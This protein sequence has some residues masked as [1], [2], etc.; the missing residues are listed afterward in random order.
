M[1]V[2]KDIM[3]LG[4]LRLNMQKELQMDLILQSLRS[5]YS[6]F[7]I[8]FH[9]N[10]LDCTIPKLVNI[11]VTTERTLKSLRGTVLAVER[12]SSER[13][14]SWKK[15]NKFAK[16]Q[17]KESKP[18]NDVPKKA[19]AKK[20]CFHCDAEGHWRRN[21]PL[22]LESLKIKKGDKLS[23]GMFVIESNL[24]ISSTSSWVLDSDSNAHI[25]TSMQGLTESRRLREGDM[26]LRVGNGAKVAA[27]VISTY[28][29]R[30]PS[31]FRRLL[32]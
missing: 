23:E 1:I 19:E 16:K 10:K 4:K 14:F 24:T 32:F 18:K 8:N 30:L 11:L 29:L 31:G 5:L 22:Y 26:I 17:K 7:I 20:K 27:E 12:T 9:I 13:K 3:K 25:Y 2:I 28:S 21:Y 6:Q 15:K